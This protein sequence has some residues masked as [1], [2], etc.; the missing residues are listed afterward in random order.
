MSRGS[1]RR[2]MWVA[3]FAVLLSLLLISSDYDKTIAIVVTSKNTSTTESNKGIGIDAKSNYSLEGFLVNTSKRQGNQTQ[4]KIIVESNSEVDPNEIERENNNS[5]SSNYSFTGTAVVPWSM[6]EILRIKSKLEYLKTDYSKLSNSE[7]G[8]LVD[9]K[10]T[11]STTLRRLVRFPGNQREA[12]FLR[13]ATPISPAPTGEDAA[14]LSRKYDYPDHWLGRMRPEFFILSP[15]KTG[16]TFLDG[17]LRHGM[18]GN[19]LKVVY[20]QASRRWPSKTTKHGEPVSTTSRFELKRRLWNRKGFRRWDVPKEP[21]NYIQMGRHAGTFREYFARRR[22]P[23]VEEESN[24]WGLVDST[25]D[26]IMIPEAAV[27]AYLDLQKSPFIPRFLVIDRDPVDRAYSH[28]MLFTD[29]K[30]KFNRKPE[31]FTVFVDRLDQQHDKLIKIPICEEALY[32]P[33][34]VVSSKDKVFSALKNCMYEYDPLQDPQV[35]YLPFGFIALGLRYWVELFGINKFL[36]LRFTDLSKMKTPTQV[37]RMFEKAFPTLVRNP[38]LC[39]N[40]SDWVGGRCTGPQRFNESELNCGQQSPYLFA[41]AWTKKSASLGYTIGDETRLAKYRE[42]GKRWQRV[43]KNMS[44][45][46][47]IKYYDS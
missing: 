11:L 28:F 9:F 31:Q 19:P 41:Q 1:T 24:H 33:E 44:D 40:P 7:F 36:L 43:L 4:D 30:K 46:L 14:A 12:V 8:K 37:V 2:L 35:Y 26:Q 22:F 27:A 16:T 6:P 23:P 5:N 17:C 20:P 13:T 3:T 38:P 42:I 10:L 39:E 15:P 34:R 18:N 47:D 29:L 21:W 25:P 45:E 32:R